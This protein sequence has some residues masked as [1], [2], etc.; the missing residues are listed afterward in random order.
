MKWFTADLHLGCACFGNRAEHF[1][2]GWDD[3]I[4]GQLERYV[5]KGD[6]L[7][8]LGDLCMG[9]PSG[10]IRRLPRGSWLIKGNHDASDGCLRDL[11]GSRFRHTY[12]V[13]V[14]GTP[15]WLSHY[16]HVSWPSSHRGS[17]HLYGHNHGEKE[18]KFNRMMPGR[19][20]MDVC[21]DNA[22]HRLG[23]WRPFS[24]DDID[25]RLKSQLGHEFYLTRGGVGDY[26]VGNTPT[27]KPIDSA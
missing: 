5:A 25:H 19:R 6:T 23:E 18:L 17:Y 27:S 2:T 20:S 8:I 26:N 7:Y 9:N 22:F 10:W 4:L 14:S 16:S 12:M 13:K 3:F 21:P 11:F 24:E 1:P 15:T